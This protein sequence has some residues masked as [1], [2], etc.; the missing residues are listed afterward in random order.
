M[1]DNGGAVITSF[2]PIINNDSRVLILGSM[3]GAESLR[4]K[5]YYA[6][7]RNQFW[8]IIYLLFGEEPEEAYEQR[9]RFL[10]D[11]GIA[12]WD[13]IE[14]CERAG[15]LDANIRNEQ[16]NRVGQLLRAYP[17]IRLVAFNGTKAYDTFKRKLGFEQDGSREYRLLPS[18]SPIPGK[19][20]KSVADKLAKWRVITDYLRKQD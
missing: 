2:P 11:K 19:N 7:P 14:K 15:S 8:P 1:A 4:Q 9:T 12:L 3:P 6:N 20:I 10:L 18:T 17:A 16:P 5:Q 13:V